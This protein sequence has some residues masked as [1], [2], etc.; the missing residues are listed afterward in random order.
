MNKH[1]WNQSLEH[2]LQQ[3]A[4][5]SPTPGGGSTAA[6]AAALGAALA[7]M[8]GKLSFCSAEEGCNVPPLE[9]A[10]EKMTK[11]RPRFEQLFAEDMEA[12]ET[13]LE[14]LKL[15]RTG[16]EEEVLRKQAVQLAAIRAVD[17]PLALMDTCRS[18]L[19][20]AVSVVEHV[21]RDVLSD[22]GSGILLLETAALSAQLTA[23]INLRAIDDPEI[24]LQYALKTAR[25]ADEI[26]ALRNGAIEDIRCRI[27]SASI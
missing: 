6:L 24:R 11:L 25:L 15:G 16:R 4:S 20:I 19:A 13:Y 26:T 1:S 18:G 10:V 9:L 23:D 7:T 27:A 21:R 8:A 22:L 17:V 12:F 3:T 14:A 5:E 2:Y